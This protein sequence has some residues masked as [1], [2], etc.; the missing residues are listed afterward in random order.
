LERPS[1]DVDLF[2]VAD[3]EGHFE[4]AVSTAVEAYRA[5]GLAWRSCGRTRPSRGCV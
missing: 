3:A 1:E 4:E 2:T 5:A